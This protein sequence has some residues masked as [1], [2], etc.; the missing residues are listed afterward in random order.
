MSLIWEYFKLSGRIAFCNY[1][2]C[3]YQKNYPPQSSTNSLISHLQFNHP[4]LHKE[5]LQKKLQRTTNR[6]EKEKNQPLIKRF[7]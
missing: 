5:F 4:E 1:K 2:N 3:K 7:E 6:E